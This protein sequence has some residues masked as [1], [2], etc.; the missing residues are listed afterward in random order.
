[1]AIPECTSDSKDTEVA[2]HN[3]VEMM[4]TRSGTHQ[5]WR[6]CTI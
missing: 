2:A 4:S 5:T 3:K 6:W 1:V